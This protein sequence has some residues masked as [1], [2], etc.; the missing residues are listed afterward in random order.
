MR[1]VAKMVRTSEENILEPLPP[2]ESFCDFGDDSRLQV[3]ILFLSYFSAQL[4]LLM[5]FFG[6]VEATFILSANVCVQ[7]F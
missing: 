2:E 3:H 4:W 1:A 6:G 5:L 7:F